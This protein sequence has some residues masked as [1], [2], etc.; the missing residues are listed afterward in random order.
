MG[1]SPLDNGRIILIRLFVK[2][3]KSVE[4]PAAPGLHEMIDDDFIA[5]SIRASDGKSLRVLRI[6]GQAC[7]SKAS[8]RVGLCVEDFAVAPE[9][10]GSVLDARYSIRHTD[11]I[12]G[13][14][15]DSLFIPLDHCRF[16]PLPEAS[17]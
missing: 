8:S 3:I 4:P 9:K 12:L 16:E 15:G 14:A 2:I 11:W 10:L 17:C 5:G 13:Q 6:R 1:A 7:L